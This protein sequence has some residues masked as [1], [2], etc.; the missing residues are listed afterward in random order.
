MRIVRNSRRIRSIAA[1]MLLGWIFALFVNIVHGCIANEPSH[2]VFNS[3]TASHAGHASD[4]HAS[5]PGSTHED[6]LCRV[7]C[8]MQ[9]S[10]AVKEKSFDASNVDRLIPHL[11]ASILTVLPPSVFVPVFPSDTLLLYEHAAFLR[12]TRLII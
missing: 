8:D 10:S 9:V 6:E 2:H 7:A 1:F 4:D 11:A 12:S 5:R 3:A